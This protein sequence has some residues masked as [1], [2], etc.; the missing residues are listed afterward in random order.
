L[1]LNYRSGGDLIIAGQ[2]ALAPAD[3]PRPYVPDPRRKD[4]GRVVFK[5]AKD[6]LADH[7]RVAAAA[8]KEALA[9]GTDPHEIAV[10]YRSKTELFSEIKEALDDDGV[11]YTAERD[12]TY[13]NSRVVRW[14]QQCSG[15]AISR[16]N[17]RETLFADLVRFYGGL[18]SES[19]RHNGLGRDM[20]HR[21]AFRSLLRDVD[22]DAPL[23]TWL[24][25]VD[26]TLGLSKALGNPRA[27]ARDERDDLVELI[28]EARSGE[29]RDHTVRDFADDGRLR[30]KIVLTTL[31]GSKGR[32][33]DVVVLPGLV[34]G[35]MPKRRWN[36]RAWEE[37][38]E[39]ELRETRRLFYVGFT[40][41]RN[42][43]YLAYGNAFTHKGYV[44]N[45]GPSRFAK[46]IHRRLKEREESA[47][48]EGSKN[49]T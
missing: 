32:Q 40:R 17:E 29:F 33:F 8:V 25:R 4:R 28:A 27:A 34:E 7:G 20:H 35:V 16:P 9:A 47:T 6:D 15:W 46:E 44:N 49:E 26:S 39:A 41:S 10:L 37:L 19:G 24:E 5:K 22:P 12:R 3:G 14:L 43:V 2:A 36:R 23:G 30:G 11:D 42:V 18:L 38:S 21:A 31:H 48:D 1:K 13:A 45:W